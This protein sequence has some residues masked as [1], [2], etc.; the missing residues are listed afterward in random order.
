METIHRTS[1][2]LQN[3]LVVT[4]CREAVPYRFADM[5]GD[6]DVTCAACLRIMAKDKAKK[7]KAKKRSGMPVRIPGDMLTAREVAE[8]LGVSPAGIRKACQDGKID[9]AVKLA[10][11]GNGLWVIPVTAKIPMVKMVPVTSYVAIPG[12]E[13]QL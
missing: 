6:D 2:W 5:R 8:R 13:R 11:C 10:T 12:S 7:D 9:G 3:G 1:R 4:R